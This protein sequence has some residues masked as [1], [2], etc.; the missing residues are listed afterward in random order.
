[1]IP[2]ARGLAEALGENYEI[3]IHDLSDPEHSILAVHNSFT[4]R[5]PGGPLT[6]FGLEMLQSEE[7][8]DM[9]YLPNYLAYTKEGR[10]IRGNCLFIRDEERNLLGFL[11]IN[12]DMT[13]ARVLEKIAASLTKTVRQ[14]PRGGGLERF[15]T[16]L[17]ELVGQYLEDAR[18]EA[19]RPL[20]LLGKP[21]KIALVKELEGKGF[22]RMKDSVEALARALGH[23]KYTIYA[24]LREAR[25]EE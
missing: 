11:C 8:Q 24:Y 18:K 4:G 15:P 23:T 1:M 3:I 10:E 19:G 22:F 6:G 20:N 14:N 21:E 9:D 25:K 5:S 12:Y 13:D 16:D 2:L 17:E 7:Y